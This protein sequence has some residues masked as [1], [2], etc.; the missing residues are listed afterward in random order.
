MTS[1]PTATAESEAIGVFVGRLRGLTTEQLAIIARVSEDARSTV[2]G[3]LEWWRATATVSRDLRR[4]RCSRRAAMASL[5]ATD[6]VRAAPAAT[7]AAHGDV[8]H[9]ARAAGEVARA[10]VAFGPV[11]GW[12]TLVP[13]WRAVVDATALN[14]R[15]DA[16]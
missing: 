12:T 10:L 4:R 9:V 3:E 1:S 7:H 8:V 14:R 6:A 16:A 2:A 11:A 13:S 5:R 15:P